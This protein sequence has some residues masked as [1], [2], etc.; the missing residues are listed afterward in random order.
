MHPTP[1][2][3]TALAVDRPHRGAYALVALAVVVGVALVAWGLVMWHF[4]MLPQPLVTRPAVM[5]GPTFVV[6]AL[7]PVLHEGVQAA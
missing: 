4:E 2:P 1:K 6:P 3:P 7:A 5:H